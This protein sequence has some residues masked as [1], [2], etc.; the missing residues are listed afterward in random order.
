MDDVR[1]ILESLGYNLKRESQK[2]WRAKPL[3]RDSG[4][5]TSM[6]IDRNTGY[7]WDFSAQISGDVSELVKLTLGLKSTDEA[8]KWINGTGYTKKERLVKPQ[9][10]MDAKFDISHL[11][12]NYKFYTN[13][14]IDE[15][16]LVEL[17][18]GVQMGG[19]MNNRLVFPI[20]DETGE[21][22]VGLA[23]RNVWGERTKWKLMGRKSKWLYPFFLNENVIDEKRE[24]IIVESIGDMLKL[25]NLGFRQILVL[26]GVKI[27]SNQINWLAAMGLERI[28]IAT[29]NDFEKD[30]NTGKKAANEIKHKIA[31][32][33]SESQ[34]QIALP[35]K[36]DFGV[37]ENDEIGRWAE[38]M[39][40]K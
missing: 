21:N 27:F 23:G 31:K 40:L 12:P 34:I 28:I 1:E 8:K 7:F 2:Y 30:E 29:N 22:V 10:E 18:C 5:P 3:Y 15:S 25:F 26:F 35:P 9:I 17:K 36:N 39:K 32:F 37:M 33:Y 14:G 11:M 24:I 20:F 16:I 6:R 38:K 4:N 19:K 13:Q